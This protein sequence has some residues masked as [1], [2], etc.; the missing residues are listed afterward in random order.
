MNSRG[1]AKA[2]RLEELKEVKDV[3]LEEENINVFNFY[4]MVKN[5]GPKPFKDCMKQ[6]SII[7]GKVGQKKKRSSKVRQKKKEKIKI[8]KKTGEFKPKSEIKKSS[9]T[10]KALPKK[11]GG[12]KVEKSKEK[13]KKK[14]L[15]KKVKE[16]KK[17]K[18]K[19]EK[20]S[21]QKAEEKKSAKGNQYGMDKMHPSWLAKKSEKESGLMNISSRNKNRVI[22]L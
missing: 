18:A 3:K 5:Y 14:E 19:E 21:K 8:L 2:V 10:A 9:K 11:K 15:N 13:E 16:K 4:D 7:L 1:R 6:V 12:K 20:A 22:E 17:E